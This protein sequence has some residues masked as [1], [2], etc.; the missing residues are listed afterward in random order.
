[1]TIQQLIAENDR[2]RAMLERDYDPLRGIGCSG[3]RV[4]AN[5]PYDTECSMIPVPMTLDPGYRLVTSRAEW[6]QLRFRHDFEYW[7]ASCVHI[8]HKTRG[9]EV[10][11]VLNAPQRRV[12]AMLEEDRLAGRPIRLIMLKARQWGGSTLIQMYFAWIQ[13]MLRRNW[14]SLICAHVKDTASTIRAIYAAMLSSYP[15]EHWAEEEK[16]R[17]A[18]FEG[19]QN[20]RLIAGRGCRVTLGSSMRQDSVRGA[21]YSMAHLT[22]VAFWGD[23]AKRSPDDF[24]RAVVG[25]VPLEPLTAV[26]MESTAN[27]VGSYFHTEWLR[28]KAGES[29]KCPVFVPWWEIE[30]YRLPV[31]DPQRLWDSMTPY[32]RRLWERGLTLEMIAWYHAKRRETR[33]DAM[34]HAEYPTDDVEAFVSCETDVFGTERV[35]QLR[36]SCTDPAEQGELAVTTNDKGHRDVSVV[37]D[38]SGC[39]KVWKRPETDTAMPV[40][41]R[42]V[43]TVDV[44]GRSQASDYSV[45][46]VLDR[47]LRPG[48]LPEVV[49]QWRG[50]ADHDMLAAK[51]ATIARW[52]GE[53]LLVV[54][55]NTLETDS[56][57]SY[58]LAALNDSYPNLYVRRRDETT[59]MGL[60]S[61]PGFHT[62][63]T[64]KMMAIDTLIAAVR[65][66]T[67]V[68]RDVGAC[69]ELATYERKQNGTYGA[70]NGHHDDILMTRAIALLVMS[71]MPPP[72]AL[73][74]VPARYVW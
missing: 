60:E 71:R 62:N 38:P 49:A 73:P 26:V 18:A 67:Y 16:P 37:P 59:A 6:Q 43:V 20:T 41:D 21:D 61:R 55:S 31:D 74:Y 28:A 53:A 33:T 17:F 24:I 22:E 57:G 64:T 65:D 13:I 56:N 35:E 70:R 54:E 4:K 48:D 8:R 12:L 44:G 10:P 72:I 32:E 68:E 27:G 5:S 11:F 34:M 7:A 52:Y 36:L 3:K 9:V 14:H 66:G 29:D 23:T 25:S 58:I 19:S 50:H 69:N 42:Y 51:A 2:R 63:R 47:G 39:M 40:R 15:A 46:A 45:I 30:M 1:M